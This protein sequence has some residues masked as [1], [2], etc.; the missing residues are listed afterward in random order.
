MKRPKGA[1]TGTP[2]QATYATYAIGFVSSVAL[3]L[4][5]YAIVAYDL[6]W[7]NMAIIAIV[8][9]AAVQLLVQLVLFLHLGREPKPRWNL[10][11]F[12]SMSIVLVIIV[13]GSLWI[14]QNLNYNMMM[15][16]EEMDALMRKESTKGF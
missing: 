1:V 7:G 15:S 12:L 13:V 5:A 11:A 6:L 3:T 16:P 9:L 2:T 14:M 4:L 8:G 10:L